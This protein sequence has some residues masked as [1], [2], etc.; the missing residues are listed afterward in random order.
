MATPD[1]HADNRWYPMVWASCQTE[2][3]SACSRALLAE[4]ERWASS[5]HAQSDTCTTERPGNRCRKAR[6]ARGVAPDSL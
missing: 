3:A 2:T 1:I 4:P 5:T 6:R